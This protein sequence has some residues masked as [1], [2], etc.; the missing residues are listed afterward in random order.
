MRAGTVIWAA[1]V[2]AS[3]VCGHAGRGVRRRDRHASAGMLVE[4]DLTLPG[5]PRGARDR[6]HGAGARAGPAARASRRWR[7]RWAATRRELV[8]D[9][10]RSR[11]TRPFKYKD[12]GNLATIG[13]ARAVAELPPGIR[14]SGFLAW[15]LWLGIHLF[16]LVG[17]QNRL[18]V[19][20]PLGLQLPH[21]RA[22][23]A[24]DHRRAEYAVAVILLAVCPRSST[25][26]PIASRRQIL[27]LLRERERSVNE[28]VGDLGMSQPAVSK[29]LRVL[30]EAGLVRCGST[31]SGAGTGSTRGR[32]PRSTRWLAPYRRYW[33][34]RLDDLERHLD[35]VVS[36]ARSARR[37][38]RTPR[39]RAPETV[40]SSGVPNV[41]HDAQ[42][43]Q[44]AA[45]VPH[46]QRHED[47][48]P[49][50]GA[51]PLRARVRPQLVEQRAQLRIVPVA[52]PAPRGAR[53]GARAT[54]RG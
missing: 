12:K 50:R 18:L 27:D 20:H 35:S 31:R 45:V 6:R 1:G 22:R 19:L 21:A 39:S 10:L 30:R 5:P 25:S 29:H 14:A 9:R 54:R 15:A 46:P 32:W 23:D 44:L 33:A 42:E 24:A 4:P 38:G 37:R 41:V 47:R 51:R 40:T 34:D 17:F 52:R 53:A 7:C 26:S 48:R 3:G 8:R 16:Y 28:L 43:P 13:R 49:G 11:D 2:L 36:V